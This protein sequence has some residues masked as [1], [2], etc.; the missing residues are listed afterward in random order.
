[1]ASRINDTLA[2]L[3]R[4]MDRIIHGDQPPRGNAEYLRE[5]IERW[6]RALADR[7]QRGLSTRIVEKQVA[8]LRAELT[9]LGAD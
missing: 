3:N 5:S 2:I 8:K 7:R 6:E 4:R 9:E 1:M